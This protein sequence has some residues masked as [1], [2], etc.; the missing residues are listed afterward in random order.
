MANKKSSVKNDLK[1][2]ADVSYK[3]VKTLLRKVNENLTQASS[4]NK[5]FSIKFM[6]DYVFSSKVNLQLFFDRQSTIPLISNSFPV[7]SSN[8]GLSFKFMLTR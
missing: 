6:A 2:S 4:G 7:S 5:L 3:D 8:F 1:L